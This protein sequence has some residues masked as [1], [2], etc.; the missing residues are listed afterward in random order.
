M[1][2]DHAQKFVNDL[3]WVLVL[4]LTRHCLIVLPLP[5]PPS[6]GYPFVNSMTLQGVSWGPTDAP[7]PLSLPNT[8]DAVGKSPSPRKL[9]L[10]GR[11]STKTPERSFAMQANIV[12]D[13]DLSGGSD[14]GRYLGDASTL[15]PQTLNGLSGGGANNVPEWL[16]VVMKNDE[17][18]TLSEAMHEQ[19]V[20]ES[21]FQFFNEEALKEAGIEKAISRAKMLR[22]IRSHFK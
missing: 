8:P 17:I 19:Q 14:D 9:Q 16:Q 1:A 13:L 6:G 22:Q 18:A 10:L 11:I 15:S 20:E 12:R 5:Y 21:D 4:W 7:P 2:P 3:C